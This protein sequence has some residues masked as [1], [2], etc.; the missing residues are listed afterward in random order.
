MYFVYV[1]CFMLCVT[2][3]KPSYDE[4]LLLKRNAGGDKETEGKNMLGADMDVTPPDFTM[5]TGLY[6]GNDEMTTP[7]PTYDQTTFDYHQEKLPEVQGLGLEEYF[8]DFAR[9]EL[10]SF[11]EVIPKSSS[12]FLLSERE[13]TSVLVVIHRRG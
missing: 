12:R 2:C 9:T 10:S 4:F 11:L 8:V 6:P 5:T 3:T 7:P 13:K 1:C